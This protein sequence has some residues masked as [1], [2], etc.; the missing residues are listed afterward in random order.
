MDG[1]VDSV[2]GHEG[3]QG[4][5]DGDRVNRVT[6]VEDVAEADVVWEVNLSRL[7]CHGR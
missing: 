6:A 5:M 7:Q 1:H 4:V 2:G 3:R